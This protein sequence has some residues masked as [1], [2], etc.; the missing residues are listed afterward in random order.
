MKATM[1]RSRIALV[2][3]VLCFVATLHAQVTPQMRPV[4]SAGQSNQLP[5]GSDFGLVLN[6][7]S[8]GVTPTQLAQSILSG[9]GVSV[10]NVQYSGVAVSAGTFSTTDTSL[11]GFSSGIVLSSGD[12]N[13]TPGP[14]VSDGTST[15]NG[16]G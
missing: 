11:L 15:A 4:L 12:I 1:W 9:S 14:N 3:G 8:T 2:A 7:L 13:S 16:L 10:T 6:D 5:K